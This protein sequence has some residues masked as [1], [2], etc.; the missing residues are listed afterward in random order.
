MNEGHFSR[1]LKRMR[2]LYRDRRAALADALAAAF[3]ERLRVDQQPGGMHLLARPIGN[4]R[5]TDLVH[6]AES[7]G[8]APTALSPLSINSDCGQGLLL[9]FTNIPAEQASEL[10]G[11]LRRAIET[12]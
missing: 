2:G 6:R 8:L 1:H 10:A 3:G 9:S 11:V 5:D 12:L 7:H 4:A